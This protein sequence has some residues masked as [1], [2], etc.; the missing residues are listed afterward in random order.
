M[1]GQQAVIGLPG[2]RPVPQ[3]DLAARAFDYLEFLESFLQILPGQVF[4]LPERD[5]FGQ[6][7]DRG[8]AHLLI[9]RHHRAHDSARSSDV[10]SL[11]IDE[12]CW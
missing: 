5:K 8:P 7:L 2:T 6:I 10:K 9:R 11:L 3:S 1:A 12:I 4:L